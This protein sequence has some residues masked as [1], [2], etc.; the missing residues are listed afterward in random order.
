[1]TND[2]E[3]KMLEIGVKMMIRTNCQ[4]PVEAKMNDNGI[5]YTKGIK[6]AIKS[7]HTGIPVSHT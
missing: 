5:R 7:D 2:V 4:W 6:I 1:M 3:Q